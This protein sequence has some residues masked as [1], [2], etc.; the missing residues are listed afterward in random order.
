M[1]L[2]SFSHDVST[3]LLVYRIISVLKTLNCPD[4]LVY[5]VNKLFSRLDTLL[6]KVLYKSVFNY[7]T[8]DVNSVSLI[9]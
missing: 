7:D 3:N 2:N 5:D 9:F 4:V 1:S 8:Y 6:H